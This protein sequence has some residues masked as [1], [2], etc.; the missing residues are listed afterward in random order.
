MR[1]DRGMLEYF[2]ATGFAGC[3]RAG[4]PQNGPREHGIV[5]KRLKLSYHKRVYITVHI[6]SP[7]WLLNIIS[8]DP[9]NSARFHF[10][11]H[12][13]LHLILHYG[14]IMWLPQYSNIN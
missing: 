6:A 1:D 10:M 2:F 11:F 12:V 4:E 8:V 3:G 7:I 13:L 9:Y 14:G 5:V